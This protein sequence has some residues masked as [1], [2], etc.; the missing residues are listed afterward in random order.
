MHK[1]NYRVLNTIVITTS[2]IETIS[3]T[4]K[5]IGRQTDRLQRKAQNLL[6]QLCIQHPTEGIVFELSAK[7]FRSDPLQR[8][9]KL[10]KAYRAYTQVI[11]R[12]KYSFNMV[13]D[14]SL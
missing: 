14:M 7:L 2:T 13:Q 12:R 9:Q 11:I 1:V 8:A 6:A 3:K 4:F 5:K 10:Q